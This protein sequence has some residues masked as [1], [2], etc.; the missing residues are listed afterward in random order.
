M[1]S[2][3]EIGPHVFSEIRK[4]DTRTDRQTDR[5]GNFIYIDT[6]QPPLEVAPTALAQ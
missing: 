4:T 6:K 3:V 5:R 1:K 2:S